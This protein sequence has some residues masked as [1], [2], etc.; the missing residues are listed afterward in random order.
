MKQPSGFLQE[1]IKSEKRLVQIY[2]QLIK[3]KR[4][5]NTSVHNC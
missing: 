4:N 3:G 1:F 2:S 5:Q